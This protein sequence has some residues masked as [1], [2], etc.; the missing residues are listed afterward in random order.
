MPASSLEDADS[1]LRIFFSHLVA[2]F[3]K[4][5]ALG[6]SGTTLP[7]IYL[8]QDKVEKNTWL[9]KMLYT[10]YLAIEERP[11]ANSKN[12]LKKVI[13]FSL[14]SCLYYIEKEKV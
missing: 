1:G 3:L 2:G 12:I 9:K 7:T 6:A 4:P 14:I 8:N 11:D 10:V 13:N 5:E